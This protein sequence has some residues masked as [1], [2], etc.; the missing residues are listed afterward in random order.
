VMMPVGQALLGDWQFANFLEMEGVRVEWSEAV[1]DSGA[2]AS[3]FER[4]LVRFRCEGRFG[5]YV[6][7]PAA[8]AVVDLTPGS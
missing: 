1:Y 7:R 5:F 4:N 8:W 3:D 2:G 6:G